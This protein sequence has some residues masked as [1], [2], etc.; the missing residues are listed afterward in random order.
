MGCK[1]CTDSDGV[2]LFPYYG[3]APHR[4]DLSKTGYLL[5]S[6]VFTDEP[7]PDNFDPDPDDSSGKI[8]TYTHCPKCGSH[9]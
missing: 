5:G 8:G 2:C 6:T 9:N 4:H 1:F 7:L 3:L